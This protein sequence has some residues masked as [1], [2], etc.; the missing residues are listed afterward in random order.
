MVP[1]IEKCLMISFPI[2]QLQA[3]LLVPETDL[4]FLKAMLKLNLNAIF[5]S[6]ILSMIP[7]ELNKSS[8]EHEKVEEKILETKKYPEESELKNLHFENNDQL[9]QEINLVQSE[10]SEESASVVSGS[11][12]ENTEALNN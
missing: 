6:S 2:N 12:P 1:F 9:V 5:D 10:L 4:K 3:V 8:V 11:M 7:R